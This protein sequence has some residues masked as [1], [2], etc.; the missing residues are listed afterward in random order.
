MLKVPIFVG[1]D[2]RRFGMKI[3]KSIFLFFFISFFLIFNIY[4]SPSF[5]KDKKVS[6]DAQAAMSYI[7]DLA[8]DS[9]L[10]RKS[11]EPGATMAEEYVAAKFKKWGVGPGGPKWSAP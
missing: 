8:A 9:M 2:D 6:F 5:A 11:G 1:I 10:G 7:K 4:I 3:P